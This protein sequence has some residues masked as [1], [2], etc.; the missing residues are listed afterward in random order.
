MPLQRLLIVSHVVHYEHEGQL[1]AYG[2]YTREIDIWADL[3]AYVAI[4]APFRKQVP[5]GDTIAFSRENISIVPMKETGGDTWGTKVIQ[6]WSVPGLLWR[7]TRA[8]RRVDAIHVRCPGNLGLLGAVMAPLFSRY[9]VAKYAGQWN[10]YPGEARTVRLQRAILRSRWWRGPVTVYGRWP[11]QPRHVIPFFTSVMTGEQMERA[12]GVAERRGMAPP[13]PYALRVLYVGRLTANKHVDL[14]LSALAILKRDG[15]EVRCDI[16]GDGDE[17]KNLQRQ[18]AQLSLGEDVTFA[19][20][21]SFEQVFDFYEHNDVLVLVSDT[22]GWPKA[23]AEGMA[24]GLACIG[25]NRGMVPQ[26][27]AEGRGIV[28]P[29]GDTMALAAALRSIASAPNE[30]AEMSQRAASWA[31]R[32]SLEGLREALRRLLESHWQVA[33]PVS[34]PDTLPQKRSGGR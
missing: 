29:P 4:A 25:S 24:F 26:M 21:V 19:G 16:V 22:E 10:G 3:F 14:L 32:Y 31:Q 30:H 1:H 33:L 28:L 34:S 20:A 23:I 11:R 5:P 6:L 8:M 13:R 27:L 2:P 18:A 9:I 17:R 7:L 15:Q 12:K